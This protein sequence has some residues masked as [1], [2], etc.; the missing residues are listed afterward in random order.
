MP[1]SS[2]ILNRAFAP[3]K[4]VERFTFD[5]H[6]TDHGTRYTGKVRNVRVSFT[7]KADVPAFAVRNLLAWRAAR[8]ARSN[9]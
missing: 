6:V 7:T 1:T 9:G 3:S 2:K 5:Q 8:F 4:S